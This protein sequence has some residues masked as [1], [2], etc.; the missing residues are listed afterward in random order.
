MPGRPVSDETREQIVAAAR[1]GKTRNAIAREFGVAGGTVTR[2]CSDAGVSFDR[3]ATEL[4]VR[5]RSIDLAEERLLVAQKMLAVASDMLDQLDAP[6]EVFNFGGK[7][8][9]FS[10]EVLDSAPAEVRRNAVVTAGIAFDKATRVIEKSDHGLEEAV[11]T[12]DVLAAGFKAAAEEIRAR[13]AT[14]AEGEP[15]EA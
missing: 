11:G 3:S 6:Y 15:D 2:I 9:T 1:E 7:D 13:E 4:A 14:P 8:N 5:A 10:S 12:L